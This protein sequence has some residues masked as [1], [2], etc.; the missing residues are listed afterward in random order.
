MRLRLVLALAVATSGCV[1][2]SDTDC[3]TLCTWWQRYCTSETVD[4]CVA[5]CLDTT[6]SA[7]QGI[8]RCVNGQGWGT[9]STCQ[10][11]GCCVR[12]VYSDYQQR[13]VQN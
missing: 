2:N 1:V 4:S 5:D 13:C 10:S 6:E 9:P 11:A 12:F 8:T 7:A 3:R